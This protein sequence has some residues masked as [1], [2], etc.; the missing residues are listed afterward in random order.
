M[1]V[2][3]K[4]IPCALSRNESI[5]HSLETL[6][7]I[8]TTD[9]IGGVYSYTIQPNEQDTTVSIPIS[10]DQTVEQLREQFSLSLSI[11]PQAGLRLGNSQ[12]SVTIVDDDG[13]PYI[14]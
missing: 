10:N 5:R 8:G 12:T 1:Q 7:Y 13:M 2:L 14:S 3:I 11:E 9:F 4:T 6:L